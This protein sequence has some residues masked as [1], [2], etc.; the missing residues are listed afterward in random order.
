MHIPSY[1]IH[2]VL[3]VYSRRLCQ[4]EHLE[5][6]DEFGVQSLINRINVSSKGKRET[7]IEKVATDIVE[8]I[9]RFGSLENGILEIAKQNQNEG[10]THFKSKNQ[11]KGEFVFNTID[12]S[13][14]KAPRKL[15]AEDSVF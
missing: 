10:K 3:K 9:T 6:Q 8:R 2:N 13:N 12:Q 4:S 15:S 5:H 14:K 1:Q 11:A 7:I